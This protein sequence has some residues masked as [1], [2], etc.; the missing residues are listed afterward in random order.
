M[1]LWLCHQDITVKKQRYSLTR[2]SVKC[3]ECASLLL[4]RFQILSA[5]ILAF[6]EILFLSCLQWLLKS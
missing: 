5:I 3:Q 1:V 2:C 6:T 4:Y